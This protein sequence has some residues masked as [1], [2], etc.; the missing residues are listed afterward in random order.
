MRLFRVLL[1]LVFI[2]GAAGLGATPLRPAFDL[3]GP[4]LSITHAGAG[5][6]GGPP[7]SLVVNLRGP[8]ELAL[9]Y[10]AGR[11]RPCFQAE[12]DGPCA[13]PEGRPYKDQ[14]IQFAGVAVEG[15]LLGTE[16]QR[17]TNA[18]PINNVGYVA[19]VTR[20][21][22]ARGTGRQAFPVGNIDPGDGLADLDGA[23]LLVI[24]TDPA[25]STPA[26]V[27]VHHGLDFAY[28]EDRTPGETQVTDPFTFNH[29]AARASARKGRLVTFA[30]DAVGIGPDRIDISRNPSLVDRLDGSSGP[31]WDADAFSVDVPAGA[32]ATTVQV[33]SEPVGRNPDSLLWVMAA[34][35]LPLPVPSG[36]TEA[37]WRDSPAAVWGP[38]GTKP[39]ERVVD[40]FTEART[41]NLLGTSTLQ[42]A[43]RF[44]REGGLL[45]AAKAVVRA[46][47]AA[48]L[49]AGHP[50][51][52]YPLTRTQVITQV[53]TALRSVDPETMFAVARGL[54]EHNG[55]GCPL[56]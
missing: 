43:L 12:P 37:F 26:R 3:Q 51:L 55:V 38:T 24:Y 19:D 1:P 23:G 42:A 49:N 27:L 20:I 50:K 13:I 21:V 35:W 33:F 45:G 16:S 14:L 39:G 15:V 6:L 25:V 30:A 18:G 22:Q 8:V 48:Y 52:E 31:S 28:G 10:W 9:L 44:Q 29:G 56:D 32:T 17:D 40:L 5:L 47:V 41:Y 36:C 7:R 53:D 54:E 11:D 46:G 2:A 4:G 34:L